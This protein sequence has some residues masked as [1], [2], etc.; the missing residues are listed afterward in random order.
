[1]RDEENKV[2][3][4]SAHITPWDMLCQCDISDP[5]EI[6]HNE[7]KHEPLFKG[8]LEGTNQCIYHVYLIK[9]PNKDEYLI[10]F[11]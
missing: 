5:I 9:N 3:I 11:D 7:I 4:Y 2:Y 10:S 1:M 8:L 6:L